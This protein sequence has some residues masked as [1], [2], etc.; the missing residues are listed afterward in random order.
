MVPA[1]KTMALATET[2][3]TSRARSM[4]AWRL[5]GWGDLRLES[6]PTPEPKPGWVKVRIRCVQPSITEC[7]LLNGERTY[8][9]ALIERALARGPAQAFGHEFSG[10]V[11]AL[12]AGVTDLQVGDR[13]AARGS[14]P[15]GIVGFD[16]PGALADY[17]V[18]PASLFVRLP[19]E[20]SDSEGAAIQPLSDAVAAVHAAHI[21][22][23]DVVVIV[24]LGSMGLACLEVA[25]F[26]GASRVVAI[27]RRAEVLALARQLGADDVIDAA[28]CDPVEAVRAITAGAGAD[29]VIETAG[30]PVS[31]GLAGNE[32]L[33]QAGRM[34]R[35]EGTVVGVAF[36]GEA[37]QLPYGVFRFRAIRFVYPSVL[38]RRL[39]ETSVHMVASG[40]VQLKPLITCVLP[41]IEQ[42]PEA[43]AR[44]AQKSRYGLINPAQV[45]ITPSGE[46]YVGT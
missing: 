34:L 10:E 32:T 39:F 26:A 24:G 2:E 5:H 12:G 17:G 19:P 27:A 9:H 42:V 45:V 30:G 20:V 23:G 43:F 16:Y 21:R 13:V 4:R 6:V 25:R 28:S 37:T 40:R 15:E 14:H 41:G 7:L 8:G 1:E 11:V 46:S 22:L 44:T 3:D 31:Q 18:F 33:V 35:D 29:V 36:D 38:T